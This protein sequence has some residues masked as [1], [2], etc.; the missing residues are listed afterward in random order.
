MTEAGAQALDAPFR[1][2]ALARGLGVTT[3]FADVLHVAEATGYGRTQLS[4]RRALVPLHP[5]RTHGGADRH[6]QNYDKQLE[7]HR[8]RRR[9]RRRR[10]CRCR[11]RRGGNRVCVNSGNEDTQSRKPTVPP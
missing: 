1:V 5:F 8:G 2:D 7:P 11:R 10:R 6:S 4:L 9:R 3:L